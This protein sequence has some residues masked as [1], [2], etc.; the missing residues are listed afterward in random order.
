LNKNR[1][2][3]NQEISSPELRVLDETG[4]NLG[5]ISREKA[6]NLANEKGLDLIEVSSSAKPPIARILSFD[7]FRYLESKK[8]KK[9]AQQKQ[10]DTK[11]V[12]VGV[13]TAKN[14]LEIKAKRA[15]K[16]LEQDHPLSIVMRMRGREKANKDWA[17]EKL[18]EFLN[19]IGIEYQTISP[20]KFGGRGIM[21]QI[22]KK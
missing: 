20:P 13:K 15:K 10:L 14:D 4:Q 6:L 12:Q 11:Q 7:K 18:Q 8:S 2:K 21:T 3:I 5:V 19:M 1:P 22:K 9:Q 16:F 17:R